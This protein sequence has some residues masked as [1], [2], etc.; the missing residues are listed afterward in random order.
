[1]N[2]KDV[3]VVM[4]YLRYCPSIYLKGLGGRESTRPVNVTDQ[5]QIGKPPKYRSEALLL[6][7]TSSVELLQGIMNSRRF[8]YVQEIAYHLA[9]R[10]CS[11]DKAPAY[12]PP[13]NT[14]GKLLIIPHWY[15][16]HEKIKKRI[17]TNI[18]TL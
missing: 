9:T 13:W 12:K 1:M 18:F 3:E 16:L 15:R 2:R 5:I 14:G 17:K 10:D 7:P 6:A 11:R 4:V 8:I